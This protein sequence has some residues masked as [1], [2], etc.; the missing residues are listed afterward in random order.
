[1]SRAHFRSILVTGANRGIG[2]ELVKQFLAQP[3]PPQWLFAACRDPHGGRAKELQ[4]LASTHPNVV[5][6]QLESTDEASIKTAAK[7]A[8]ALLA[9]SG[10]TLLINNAAIMPPSTLE[11]VTKEDM[12]SVYQTNLVGPMLTTKAFLP[13]LKTAAKKSPEKELS[14]SKAAIVNVSTIG[15]S[16]GDAPSMDMF[17]VVAYRCSKIALNMLTRCQALEYKESGILSVAIHPGWV[18]TELG[19]DKADLTVEDSTSGI[20][21]VLSNLS[22]E[23]NGRLLNWEGRYISW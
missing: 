21:T 14:G 1:M 18:K 7:E 20:I 8:E 10:L 6:L 22:E 15:S 23:Q 16:I 11:S 12:L 4:A 19:T 17:P 3:K 2:L 13:L 9:G 5:I